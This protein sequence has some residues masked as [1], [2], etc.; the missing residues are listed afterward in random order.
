[1]LSAFAMQSYNIFSNTT[2][3]KLSILT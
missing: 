3:K 2:N 1:V